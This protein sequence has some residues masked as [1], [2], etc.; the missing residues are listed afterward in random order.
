MDMKRYDMLP[1]EIRVDTTEQKQTLYTP[2]QR[3]DKIAK[4]NQTRNS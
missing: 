4:T 3:V 1:S 2:E